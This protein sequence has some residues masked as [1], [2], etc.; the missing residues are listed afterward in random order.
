MSATAGYNGLQ[1]VFDTSSSVDGQVTSYPLTTNSATGFFNGD[2]VRM[3]SGVITPVTATPTTTLGAATPWGIFIGAQYTDAS[4]RPQYT[5]YFPANGYTSFSAYGTITLMVVNDP[6]VRFEVQ[7]DGAITQARI[8]L[9]AQLGNFSAGSTVT[10]NS[11]VNLVASSVA[12]TNTFGVK[13]IDIAAGP[14]NAA[15]DAFTR[16]VCIWNQNVHAFKNILGA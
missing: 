14:D 2:I 7:A 13:I 12:T 1:V 15:G 6:D 11:G 4:G 16:V 9:N 10:G 5:Q 8:G 3:A